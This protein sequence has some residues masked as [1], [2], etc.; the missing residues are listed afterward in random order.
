MIFARAGDTRD[1]MIPGELTARDF[2]SQGAGES[3][4]AKC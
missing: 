3:R 4:S 1:V 2:G